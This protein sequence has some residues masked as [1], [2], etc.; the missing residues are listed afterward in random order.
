MGCILATLIDTTPCSEWENRV[1]LR[2]N[3]MT[4]NIEDPKER[5]QFENEA[6]TRWSSIINN[7]IYS[8]YRDE[9]KPNGIYAKHKASQLCDFLYYRFLQVTK[10][11]NTH[12]EVARKLLE[13]V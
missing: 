8:Y 7:G 12:W 3:N 11:S 4:N 6:K 5:A 10:A 9:C 1:A 13:Y 2:I